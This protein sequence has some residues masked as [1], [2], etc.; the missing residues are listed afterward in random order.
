MNATYIEERAALT[1]A[2]PDI[3]DTSTWPS[4]DTAEDARL[5]A[6]KL[7]ADAQ[8][9]VQHINEPLYR[10]AREIG[11]LRGEVRALCSYITFLEQSLKEMK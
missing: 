4:V 2:L 7:I 1:Q 8:L 5:N 11:M 6:N 10:M 3:E 9:A